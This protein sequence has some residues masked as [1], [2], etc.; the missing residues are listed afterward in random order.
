[1]DTKKPAGPTIMD[2]MRANPTSIPLDTDDPTFDLG[3]LFRDPHDNPQRAPGPINIQ[4]T[5]GGM[6]FQGIPTFFRAPVALGPEDLVA[7]QVDV[8][9]MGASVDSTIGIRGT[10]WGPQALRTAETLIPW[11]EMMPV[12]HPSVGDV[13]FM[14]VLKLV[15]YG[16]API[17]PMS[18]ERSIVPIHRMVSE[19]ARSGAIPVIIGGDHSLMYPDVVAVTDVHGK[20]DVGVIHFDAHFDG[21]G[22]MFGHALSNGSPV[23][24]L[25]EEGHVRGR[26]FIQVG[27]NSVKPGADDMAWMREQ[28]LRYHFMSEIEQKGWRRVLELATAEA[29]DG[30]RKVFVS[31]DI[32]VLDLTYA[33]GSG[34]PEPGGM[35][36][37]ELFPMLRAIGVQNEIVG[38][39]L[40]EV[41]PLLDQTYRTRLTALR[42]VRELLTGIAMRR[43]GMTDPFHQDPDYLEHGVARGPVG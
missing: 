10:A 19:I 27:L 42:I 32:D 21:I 2:V 7:G 40:V 43:L 25:L 38:I 36:V 12:S 5:A 31:L 13:D 30:P 24:R 41:N 29:L 37:R 26:N 14:R 16:D 6:A 8:A 4:K 9:V 39:E 3:M 15:D 34:T 11:G 18:V 17:D 22:S 35:S 33:P 23:R 20:G 28:Q 1:M